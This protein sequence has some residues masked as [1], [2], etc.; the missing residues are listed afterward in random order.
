MK[1]TKTL[2]FLGILSFH[3]NAT[4]TKT[5]VR[6]ESLAQIMSDQWEP[7]EVDQVESVS[8]QSL[9][10][11]YHE[12]KRESHKELYKELKTGQ[13]P[14]TI[15]ISCSDSRVD[16]AILLGANPGDLFVVRNVANLV[17][18][19]ESDVST[20]HGTSAALEFGV[21]GLKIT[22]IIVIGHSRCAGIR[23][24]F[25]RDF[26]KAPQNF[27]EKWMSIA[28]PAFDYAKKS[29]PKASE[30]RQAESCAHYSVL[31]SLQ[32]LRKF[33]WIADKEKRGELTLHGW[34]FD[35]AKGEIQTFDHK[36]KRWKSL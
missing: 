31:N 32:N 12:F 24:L 17:P 26:S 35:I 1:H 34:F 21:N 30:D 33:K 29:D 27:V 13:K 2:F 23:S 8:I 16:P 10:D 36:T 28:Q 11:G 4:Y 20:Y 25:S 7:K 9:I 22:N 19:C 15:V 6:S 5:C 18:P 3:F 14:K